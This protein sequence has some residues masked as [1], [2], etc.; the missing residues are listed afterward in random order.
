MAVVHACHFFFFKTHSI[1]LMKV[2]W[3]GV[4]PAKPVYMVQFNI[5]F[6]TAS[7]I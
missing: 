5:E 1:I 2:A 7:F 3:H 6:S 4:K